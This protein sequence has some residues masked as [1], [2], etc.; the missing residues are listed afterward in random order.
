[1]AT[2]EEIEKIVLLLDESHPSKFMKKRNETNAGIGAVL[3]FLFES[4]QPM[5]AGSI[6][7]FMNVSTA[8]VAVLLKKMEARGFIFRQAGTA[9]ART[10]VVSLTEA[11]IETASKMQED[12]HRDIG[13]LIDTIGMER[14]IEYTNISREI[15]SV[16]KGPSPD[17]IGEE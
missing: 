13:V 5:T 17:I 15:R 16:I 3:R 2:R 12:F 4:G 9:D 10:V 11:G 7:Q 1:M 14:L 8:R 6:S